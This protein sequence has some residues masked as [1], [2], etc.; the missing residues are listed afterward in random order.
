MTDNVQQELI[1][2][3]QEQ[4]RAVKVT[5]GASIGVILI[6]YFFSFATLV[7]KFSSIFFVF[8]MVTAIVFTVVLFQLNRVSFAWVKFRNRSDARK[9]GLLARMHHNDVDLRPEDVLQMLEDEG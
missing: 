6:L 5:I 8:Q 4:Q 2:Q 3:L 9:S 7:D 1:V